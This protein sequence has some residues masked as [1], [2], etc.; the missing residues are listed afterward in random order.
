MQ[1]R[2]EKDL[3][4]FVDTAQVGLHWVASDGT[5]LWANPADYEPLGYSGVEYIERRAGYQMHLGKP[6]E[7]AEFVAVLTNLAQ[8]ALAIS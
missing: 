1:D 8:L 7:P 4:D 3:A 5:I 2:T 6:V